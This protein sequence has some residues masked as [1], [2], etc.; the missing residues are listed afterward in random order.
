MSAWS[1][2]NQTMVSENVVFS[3]AR[4]GKLARL[5]E[6]LDYVEDI[7]EK[8]I[9]GHSLLMLSAFGGHQDLARYLISKGADVNYRDNSGTS[10][11]M[12]VSFRGDVD[13][14]K[15]LV[16]AGADIDAQNVLG[17][18]ALDYALMFNRQDIASFISQQK[19]QAHRPVSGFFKSWYSY[20]K[21]NKG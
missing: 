17:Q 8:N 2:F 21:A 20:L 11:L 13:L 12:G 10:I 6:A 18:T 4:E 19:N 9:K 15:M 14:F 5:I 7:N 16:N 1:E 3:Y